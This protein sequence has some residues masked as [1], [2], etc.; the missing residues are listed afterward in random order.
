MYSKEIEYLLNVKNYLISNKEYFEICDSSPQI[1][2]VEYKAYENNY[3]I[4]TNDNYNF[5]F[6]VYKKEENKCQR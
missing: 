4:H 5:T 6:K 2:L 3:H 1:D